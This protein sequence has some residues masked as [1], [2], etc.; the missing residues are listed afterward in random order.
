MNKEK[1]AE[2]VCNCRT[3]RTALHPSVHNEATHRRMRLIITF[4][5]LFVCERQK[6]RGEK[7]RDAVLRVLLIMSGDEEKEARRHSAE[8]LHRSSTD[9]VQATVVF[10]CRSSTN[11]IVCF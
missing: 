2:F 7:K 1:I 8:F 11:R 10:G 5:H 9:S 3:H 4:F 6:E